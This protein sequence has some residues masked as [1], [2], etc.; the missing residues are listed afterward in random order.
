MCVFLWIML[1]VFKYLSIKPN[2]PVVIWGICLRKLFQHSLS[3][4]ISRKLSQFI[5]RLTTTFV[6]SMIFPH[7]GFSTILNFFLFKFCLFYSLWLFFYGSLI[8][9]YNNWPC[10]LSKR[11][12]IHLHMSHFLLEAGR[13]PRPLQAALL[14]LANWVHVTKYRAVSQTC[15]LDALIIDSSLHFKQGLP[16]NWMQQKD[17]G[18][19]IYSSLLRLFLSESNIFLKMTS[20]QHWIFPVSWKHRDIASS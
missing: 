9:H 3:T 5:W 7:Q 10:L 1:H 17:M 18:C 4:N 8:G 13:W 14:L 12:N 16:S 6:S 2:I 15:K 20:G 19:D 11:I